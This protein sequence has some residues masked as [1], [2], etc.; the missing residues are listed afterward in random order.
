MQRDTFSIP[1]WKRTLLQALYLLTILLF[2]TS[3]FR[4]F[5]PETGFTSLILFGDRQEAQATTLL[6]QT[7]HYVYPDSLGYDGQFYAQI[8]LEPSLHNPE[9]KLALDSPVTRSRRILMP[10]IAHLLGGGVPFLVLEAYATINIFCWLGI[11]ALLL[12]WM[13]PIQFRNWM[14]WTAC[15]FSFGL[16]FSVRRS[17][18]DGPSALLLLGALRLLEKPLPTSAAGLIGLAALCR[19]TSF[20]AA[21]S[22]LR[23]WPPKRSDLLRWI[24]Y[25]L[26]LV[27][28]LALWMI[29]LKS[30]YGRWTAEEASFTWPLW[31]F[32]Q[33]ISETWNELL[34]HGRTTS[35][36][37]VALDLISLITQIVFLLKYR[38]WK[39]PIWQIAALYLI[40]PFAADFPIWEGD[41]MALMRVILPLTLGFNLLVI[42]QKRSAL[43][44]LMGNLTVLH[45]FE[46]LRIPV[47]RKILGY[48]FTFF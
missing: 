36:R 10:G 27:L 34:L 43:W 39:N 47:F 48:S 9:F 31:Q 24:R 1:P 25:G 14:A 45:G 42:Q 23:P 11:A 26:V 32:G 4:G 18:T 2:V 8:A 40:F 33:K 30:A 28:P 19:E 17:L 22:L 41:S 21:I 20:L 3:I 13:P 6:R 38:D 37:W 16:L 7:P 35:Y 44:L 29:Y 15:L 12:H 5:Q 46:C